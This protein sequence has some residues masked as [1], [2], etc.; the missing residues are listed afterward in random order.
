ML[1]WLI[2]T[3]PGRQSQ[4]ASW[5]PIGH[6]GASRF[7]HSAVQGVA[8]QGL[9]GGAWRRR[10]SEN[11]SVP[12]L[13]PAWGTATENAGLVAPEQGEGCSISRNGWQPS[14]R[15][16]TNPMTPPARRTSAERPRQWREVSSADFSRHSSGRGL[17]QSPGAR[18]RAGCLSS[19]P[20]I[21]G[22]GCYSPVG[23]GPSPC[24]KEARTDGD[25]PGFGKSGWSARRGEASGM[26][27]RA[28][29]RRSSA[30]PVDGAGRRS[31]V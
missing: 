1:R 17:S 29:P 9:I 2:M 12:A 6:S 22:S 5:H 8:P 7:L 14:G 21:P 24:T 10:S 19:A 30:A 28:Q 20:A 16:S 15:T 18:V 31:P 27:R 4:S 3:C 11:P 25:C 13:E 26:Q 23:N